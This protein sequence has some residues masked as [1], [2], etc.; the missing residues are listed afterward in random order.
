MIDCGVRPYC[1]LLW[2]WTLSLRRTKV[3]ESLPWSVSTYVSQKL[4]RTY[5]EK[6]VALMRRHAS[7]SRGVHSSQKLRDVLCFYVIFQELVHAWAVGSGL[8]TN[9]SPWAI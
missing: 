6:G 2:I 5:G 4:T 1:I 3:S 8:W 7:E 9:S